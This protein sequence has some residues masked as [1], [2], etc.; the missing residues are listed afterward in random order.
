MVDC[1]GAIN[2][3]C[4]LMAKSKRDTLLAVPERMLEKIYAGDSNIQWRGGESHAV[5]VTGDALA[6]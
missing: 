4:N 5:N 3:R 2:P 6:E 1:D